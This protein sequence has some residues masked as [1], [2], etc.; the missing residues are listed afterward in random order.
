MEGKEKGHNS[1][2]KIYRGPNPSRST[3]K[4]ERKKQNELAI[5]APGSLLKFKP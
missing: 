3:Q 4:R 1:T 2:I 5:A